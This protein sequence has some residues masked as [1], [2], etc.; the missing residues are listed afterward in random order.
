MCFPC[1]E[2]S[3]PLSL[4]IYGSNSNRRGDISPQ[5]QL[6]LHISAEFPAMQL[7]SDFTHP[8]IASGPTG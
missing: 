8:E 5:Q 4:Y 2:M 1:P 3:F 6:I 7:N